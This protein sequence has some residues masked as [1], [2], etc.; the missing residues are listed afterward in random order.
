MPKSARG[1]KCPRWEHRKRCGSVKM[2]VEVYRCLKLPAP[3]PH[4][5]QMFSRKHKSWASMKLPINICNGIRINAKLRC[6][7][8]HD[9]R[10]RR[11]CLQR[12]S[13]LLQYLSVY[14]RLWTAK[15]GGTKLW[16]WGKKI[17]NTLVMRSPRI[18][19]L[20]RCAS[21]IWKFQ[22]FFLDLKQQ[23]VLVIQPIHPSIHLSST[24]VLN[25]QGQ[26]ENRSHLLTRVELPIPITTK[27]AF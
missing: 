3:F 24:C 1:S 19:D 21:S 22:V 5:L 2:N 8:L 13:S 7:N 15:L 11:V 4:K 17:C 26:D 27:K 12:L 23:C 25:L 10:F 20:I 6:A 9:F 14:L 16:K 18:S